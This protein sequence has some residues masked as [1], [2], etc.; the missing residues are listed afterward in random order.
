MALPGLPKQV[1]MPKESAN[2]VNGLRQ[3][4]GNASR[5]TSFGVLAQ[6]SN[7]A[8]IFNSRVGINY[9]GT[10]AMLNGG[11]RVVVNN[12]VPMGRADNNPYAELMKYQMM[13]QMGTQ[14]ATGIADIVKAF[15]SDGAGSTPKASTPNTPNTPKTTNSSSTS[16]SSV[17]SD[18]QNAKDSVTLDSAIAVANREK[19]AIPG[20]IETAKGEL[21]KLKG[22]TQELEQTKITT[23][24][25]LEAHNNEVKAKE[26]DVA[27]KKQSFEACQT[28]YDVAKKAYDDCPEYIA[29]ADG[30]QTQNPQKA[31]LKARMDTEKAKLDKAKADHDAA[32]KE[33][34][35]LKAKTKEYETKAADA[36]EAFEKNKKD[37]EAKEEAIKNL[38]QT[39]KDLPKEITNQQ[40]RLKKLRAKED[41]ELTN[42]SNELKNIENDMKKTSLKA[43]K[44]AELQKKQDELKAK[45]KELEKRKEM[46][47]PNNCVEL[48][49]DSNGQ[50]YRVYNLS[51]GKVYLL[52]GKEVSQNYYNEQANRNQPA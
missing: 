21:T 29:G 32:N 28:S 18:M 3:S 42:I 14:V 48:K 26:S 19:L 11:G 52:N 27:T 41:K 50:E 34:T 44:K 40:E 9:A 43:D 30:Q 7:R 45:Q 51:S 35:D 1:N 33:L 36:E 25:E 10:R 22:E 31:I 24:N 13:M 38:E 23:A 2:S 46:R 6:R 15:K 37:I 39:Q 47:K 49:Y 17:I 16:S 8:S 20:K 5:A 4:L 12:H